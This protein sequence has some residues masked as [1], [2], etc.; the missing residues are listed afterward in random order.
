VFDDNVTPT[1]HTAKVGGFWNTTAAVITEVKI[2]C[3]GGNWDVGSVMALY[4]YA[5]A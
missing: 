5:L 4:G 1:R 3:A 2:A